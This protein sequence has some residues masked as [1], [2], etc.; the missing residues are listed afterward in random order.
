MAVAGA[1][2]V[3][4]RDVVGYDRP[5]PAPAPVG[6]PEPA[7]APVA[8]PVAAPVPAAPRVPAPQPVV[9]TVEPGSM[10]AGLTAAT[11]SDERSALRRIAAFVVLMTL[12]LATA[13]L[14]GAGIYRTVAGLG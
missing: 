3:V 13:A 6:A 12:T 1:A 5:P 11:E 9:E 14:V 10:L 7:P 2:V 8:A 4:L